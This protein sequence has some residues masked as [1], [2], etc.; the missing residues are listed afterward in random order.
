MTWQEAVMGASGMAFTGVI[1]VVVIVQLAATWRA[2]ASVARE[3][4]YRRLAEEASQAHQRTAQ[5]LDQVLVELAAL[6]ERMGQLQRV[7]KEVEE[8]W[9]Q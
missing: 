8:P 6:Q 5:Q 4:A 3:E 2:R 7:L 1:V 9:A